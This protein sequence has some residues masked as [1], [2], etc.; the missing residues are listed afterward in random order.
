MISV[1][2]QVQEVCAVFDK[3]EYNQRPEVKE[4]KREYAQ[5]PEVKERQKE[6][7]QRYRQRPEVKERKREYAQRPEV[8]EQMKKYRESIP[9]KL[10]DAKSRSKKYNFEFNLTEEYL[11]SIYPEDGMCP[12]LNIQLNWDS[13]AKH[14]SKPSLDRIDNNKG[15]IKGNVQWVS[16]RANNLMKDASPD[17]LLMLAQNYKKVYDDALV[18]QQ[19]RATDF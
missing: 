1:R 7:A 18:A 2:L 16:W 12:L 4:R 9:G 19:D 15:Y 13:D 17:E 14:P 8:R 10:S 3:K 5:R 6:Y 11:K